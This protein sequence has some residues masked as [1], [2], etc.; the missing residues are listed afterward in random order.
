[1]LCLDNVSLYPAIKCNLAHGLAYGG[2]V[3]MGIG[4][5]PMQVNFFIARSC[6]YVTCCCHFNRKNLLPKYSFCIH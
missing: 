4:L 1:M 6:K 2:C 5:N 3:Q